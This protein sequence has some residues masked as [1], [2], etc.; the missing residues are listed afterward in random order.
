MSEVAKHTASVIYSLSQRWK[1]FHE[2]VLIG[3]ALFSQKKKLIF[4]Q[5]GRKFGKTEIALYCL[6]RWC[7]TMRNQYCYYIAPFQKQAKEIIWSSNRIQTFGDAKFVKSINNSENRITFYNDSFIKVDGSDNFEALRGITCHFVIYEEFKD[8]NEQFHEA[9]EP[10][11]ATHN[12]PLLIIGTPPKVECQYT[13]L[14]EEAKRSEFKAYFEFPTE[15]NPHI[16]KQWLKQKREELYARGEGDV[17]EREYCARFVRGGSKS[18]FPMFD[19]KVFVKDYDSLVSEISRDKRKL[20]FIAVADPGSVTCF[21]VLFL[22]INKYS[23][24]VYIFD[25]I[26]ETDRSKTSVDQIG[27]RIIDIERNLFDG[28]W[29]EVYDCA[30]AWFQLEMAQRFGHNFLPS[31]KVTKN[32]EAV[33]SIIKDLFLGNKIKVSS[34]CE[35]FCWEVENYVT[36]DRGN[37]PKEDDHLIDCLRYGLMS[38]RYDFNLEVEPKDLE[39]EQREV[40]RYYTPE[41]DL[42]GYFDEFRGVEEW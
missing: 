18:I 20:Y 14:A 35:K 29:L 8:F 24:E 38:I 26:Y 23:R 39:F 11:L 27:Q 37:I 21:A 19:R 30:E 41:D 10:N 17:W 33:L 25:E 6:W 7:L 32:K 34:R 4:V 22:A 40:I 15:C 16:D 13:K 9:M 42:A 28:E 5:C 1:P 12:A 3:N 36:D 31:D 2:Q